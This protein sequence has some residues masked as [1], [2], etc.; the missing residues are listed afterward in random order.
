MD[1]IF[2]ITAVCLIGAVLTALL[3]KNGTEMALLLT[4]AVAAVVLLAL[5]GAV[6]DITDLVT[7]MLH[8]GSIA[9]E[10]FVPLIKTVAI[11]LVSRIGAELCRDAGAGAIAQIPEEVKLLEDAVQSVRG[12]YIFFAAAPKAEEYL[13]VFSNS[14]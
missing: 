13:E 9:P 7:R 3:R 8:A 12:T 2:Q 6:R 4:L 11:A 1:Q 5:G 14:L 10:L